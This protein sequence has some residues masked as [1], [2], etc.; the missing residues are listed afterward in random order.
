[1]AGL[2]RPSTPCFETL[3]KKGVDARDKRGHDGVETTIR[4][5]TSSKISVSR[6]GMST[7]T[8]WPHGTS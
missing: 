1:M 3:K 8:S 7:I 4:Y 2:S 5:A 6:S